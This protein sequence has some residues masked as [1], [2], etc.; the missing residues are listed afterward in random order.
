MTDR[1]PPGL[2]NAT[3]IG[4][5]W[6][7]ACPAGARLVPRDLARALLS[8]GGQAALSLRHRFNI[9]ASSLSDESPITT[10]GVRPARLKGAPGGELVQ[11]LAFGK[12]AE[13]Q[14]R[15]TCQLRLARRTACL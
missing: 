9:S 3:A 12:T 8:S 2:D 6:I 11:A 5:C 7:T 1:V 13:A 15:C 10:Y 14:Y 4:L